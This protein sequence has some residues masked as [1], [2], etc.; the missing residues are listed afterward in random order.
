MFSRS[1]SGSLFKEILK[2][3][4]ADD[5][6]LVKPDVSIVPSDTELLYESGSSIESES[7]DPLHDDTLLQD[8]FYVNEVCSL[9]LNHSKVL[10]VSALYVISCMFF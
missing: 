4:E 6:M 1:A 5:T 10:H 8:L 7:D 9:F 2:F 3:G